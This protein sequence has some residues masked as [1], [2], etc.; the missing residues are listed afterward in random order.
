MPKFEA[1]LTVTQTITKTYR[2]TKPISA[3]DEEVAQ[4][5]FEYRAP[6]EENENE[7]DESLWDLEEEDTDTTS[8]VEVEETDE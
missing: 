7:L 5:K 3:K 8:E 6:N 4:E 2:S 1:T